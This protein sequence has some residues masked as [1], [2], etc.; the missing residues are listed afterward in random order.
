[1]QIR[2]IKIKSYLQKSELFGCKLIQQ[3]RKCMRINSNS[4]LVNSHVS[5]SV[6]TC[7]YMQRACKKWNRC[8][9][10]FFNHDLFHKTM[11]FPCMWTCRV[12][13]IL[14]NS[15]HAFEANFR[16]SSLVSASSCVCRSGVRLLSSPALHAERYNGTVLLLLRHRLLCGIWTSCYSLCQSHWLDVLA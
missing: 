14:L 2:L 4:F 13:W 8:C 10:S 6:S 12:P 9:T 11:F 3:Y 5:L 15:D 16:L 1:M 7:I